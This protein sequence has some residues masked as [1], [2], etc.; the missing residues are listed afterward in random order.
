MKIFKGSLF[1]QDSAFWPRRPSHIT[2]TQSHRF[3]DFLRSIRSS[4]EIPHGTRLQRLLGRLK[5]VVH[6]CT[7]FR[8]PY[9]C[10][11][12][13]KY[14]F[15]VGVF[16]P[17]NVWRQELPTVQIGL[18][19]NEIAA[20]FNGYT[21]GRGTNKSPWNAH[22]RYISYFW[23]NIK[24]KQSTV[25]ENGTWWMKPKEKKQKMGKKCAC[26]CVCVYKFSVELSSKL[27]GENKSVCPEVE[28]MI[29][30][31]SFT[32]SFYFDAHIKMFETCGSSQSSLEMELK[33]WFTKTLVPTN[34]PALVIW[35]LKG[36]FDCEYLPTHLLCKCKHSKY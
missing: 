5:A 2:H 13:V 20:N 31:F 8:M 4:M 30:S 1:V 35:Y 19:E 27:S 7:S 24:N 28:R 23:W 32:V 11:I 34:F 6:R 9:V 10:L 15:C 26:V 17:Y 14:C 16:A 36:H 22:I 3:S 21:N 33:T 18:S 29:C 25:D 12:A